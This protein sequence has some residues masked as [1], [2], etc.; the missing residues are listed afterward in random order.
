MSS[1]GWS[2]RGTTAPA[3]PHG[4]THAALRKECGGPAAAVAT[5]EQLHARD[6]PDPRVGAA[7]DVLTVPVGPALHS[8]R[9]G[10][11]LPDPGPR[12][13]GPRRARGGRRRAHRHRARRAGS[14]STARSSTGWSARSSSTRWCAATHGAGC[15]W[16]S[17]CCT[18][19]PRS[20]PVLRDLAVPVLRE[21]AEAV[22]CTAHLTVA[23]GEEALA[24]AVVEPSWTDFHVSYR[25][26]SRHPLT[27]G[28]PPVRRS[29]SAGA[30]DPAP[31]AVTEGELQA[32]ARGLA[33]PVPRR[34]RPR[35]QRRHRDAGLRHR[36]RH[37]RAPGPPRRRAGRD[38]AVLSP[39]PPVPACCAPPSG[40]PGRVADARKTH[41]Y[42]VAPAPC[43]RT[44]PMALA[45]AAIGGSGLSP[46]PSVA[47]A[48]HQRLH[49]GR[50]PRELGGGLGSDGFPGGPL[51]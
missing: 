18:W 24:L 47:E 8:A 21:L 7:Q 36:R 6:R 38:P 40:H 14:T 27:P 34:R 13:A 29:C 35:G 45:T 41:R 48:A 10:R 22:G 46:A 30:R 49:L 15:T 26:G 31:F 17:A 25:V 39:D 9:A 50:H 23:D 28:A 33:A 2:P 11:D 19:P 42:A 44:R 43:Q 3:R 20:Q 4:I 1:T 12:A 32:G 51:C 5:A 16:A 37:D